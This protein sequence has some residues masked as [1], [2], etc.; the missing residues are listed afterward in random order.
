MTVTFWRFWRGVFVFWVV[1]VL[2]ALIYETRETRRR[3]DNL[4]AS[5]ATFHGYLYVL[6]PAGAWDR[7]RADQVEVCRARSCSVFL[8]GGK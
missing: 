5:P 7:V 1:A 4:G 8:A 2:F 6:N 3:L